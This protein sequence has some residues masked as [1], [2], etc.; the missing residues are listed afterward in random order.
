MM[1]V[2]VCV[3]VQH[4]GCYIGCTAHTLRFLLVGDLFDDDGRGLTCFN[5]VCTSCE[6]ENDGQYDT[7]A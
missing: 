4:T 2:C 1:C 3:C 5:A 6:L 7:D